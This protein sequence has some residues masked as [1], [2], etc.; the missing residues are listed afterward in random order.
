[1]FHSYFLEIFTTKHLFITFFSNICGAFFPRIYFSTE[2]YRLRSLKEADLYIFCCCA[3]RAVAITIALETGG[4][5]PTF[6]VCY[7]QHPL[8][9]QFH[10][11]ADQRISVKQALLFFS[12]PPSPWAFCF[13]SSYSGCVS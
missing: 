9:T 2:C 11:S 5:H 7:Q 8:C 3:W 1:M 13:P 6:P 12:P 4:I 10:S